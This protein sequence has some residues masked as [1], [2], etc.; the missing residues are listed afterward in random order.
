MTIGRDAAEIKTFSRPGISADNRELRARR[1]R[2]HTEK[3]EDQTEREG[4]STGVAT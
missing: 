2:D 3:Q 1:K 4:G